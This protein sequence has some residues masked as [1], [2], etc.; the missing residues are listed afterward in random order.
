MLLF[1][2][3]YCNAQK[4]ISLGLDRRLEKEKLINSFADSLNNSKKG[5]ALP[6]FLSDE[7]IDCKAS[8]WPGLH[9]PIS[10]RKK[11]LSK[12]NNSNTLL[13]LI[14]SNN[15]FLKKICTK[16]PNKNEYPNIKI[17]DIHKTYYELILER[18]KEIKNM[19]K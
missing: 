11:I 12:V 9:T 16:K 18:I 1:P 8:F 5:K 10:V 14:K 2:F 19:K 3:I 17:P 13:I 15:V 7:C 4:D 6:I